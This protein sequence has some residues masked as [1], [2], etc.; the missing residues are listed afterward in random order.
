[1]LKIELLLY[2]GAHA[3]DVWNMSPYEPHGY[4]NLQSFA[5]C[6]HARELQEPVPGCCLH[7]LLPFP[8]LIRQWNCT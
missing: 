3:L 6:V 8:E 7:A 5:H 1:M 4:S 2:C